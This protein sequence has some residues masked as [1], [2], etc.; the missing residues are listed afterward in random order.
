MRIRRV[1]LLACSSVS[2][3]ATSWSSTDE[4]LPAWRGC[5]AFIAASPLH[6]ASSVSNIV[7]TSRP[8]DWRSTNN[9]AFA[10][11]R[12]GGTSLDAAKAVISSIAAS[13]VAGSPSNRATR[14]HVCSSFSFGLANRPPHADWA[15]P[16][17]AER[18]GTWSPRSSRRCSPPILGALVRREVP[19][20]QPSASGGHRR[21]SSVAPPARPRAT[22]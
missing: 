16:G 1:R 14:A 11:A 5:P 22:V 8:P 19:G 7:I 4:R 13:T 17:V 21:C 6:I 15:A 12:S 10:L 20:G 18:P 2:S 9:S 3:R